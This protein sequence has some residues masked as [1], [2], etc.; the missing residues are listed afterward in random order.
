MNKLNRMNE[1][2]AL[3][4]KYNYAYYTLDNPLI[5]DK[6][7]DDLYYELVSLESKTGIIL[8]NSPTQKVGDVV[9]DKFEK[10]KHEKKLYSLNKANTF[11]ELK[12]W[13]D[14]MV[15]FGAKHFTIEY[16]YDGLR[17][18]IKYE[19]GLI[20]QCATRGNGLVG[21]NITEQVK[22]IRN[23]PKSIKYRGNL[24]VMGEVMMKLSEL[25]KYNRNNPNVHK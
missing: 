15:S 12:S 7:Y 13:F 21:E 18:V 17:V 9:L 23:V 11:D 16:K 22:T 3:I 6:E 2:I 19:N 25:E 5:S 4:D 10:V 1:L 8:P 24:T 20:K 14:D